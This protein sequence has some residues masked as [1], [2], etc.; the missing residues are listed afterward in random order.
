MKTSCELC[1]FSIKDEGTQI[2]CEF[3]RLA[4][5]KAAGVSVKDSEDGKFKIIEGRLCNTCYQNEEK[6]TQAE[7]FWLVKSKIETKCDIII[8]PSNGEDL[9]LMVSQINEMS[10]KP[11]TTIILNKNRQDY[12]KIVG[13]LKTPWFIV[14]SVN[15]EV[16]LDDCID[17]VKSPYFIILPDLSNQDIIKNIDFAINEKMAFFFY[18]EGQEGILINTEFFRYFV[19]NMKN[20]PYNFINTP[21]EL[22]IKEKMIF[23]WNQILPS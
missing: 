2:G 18:V 23:T 19:G 16:T 22:E 15:A 1:R 9:K 21:P 6:Y 13:T 10:L 11:A 5:F 7:A 20:F 8:E 12:I 14:S 3:D 17:K 4:K